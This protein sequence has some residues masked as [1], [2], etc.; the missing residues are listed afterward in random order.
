MQN[1]KER[2]SFIHWAIL[3]MPRS[4]RTWQAKARSQNA[5]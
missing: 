3:Q 4:S 1:D 2:E 5:T